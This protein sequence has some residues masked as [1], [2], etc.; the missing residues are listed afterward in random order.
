MA[1]KTG[2]YDGPE[3][4]GRFHSELTVW[5]DEHDTSFPRRA[6]GMSLSDEVARSRANQSRLWQAGW[7][8]YGWPE[9][10]GGLGGSRLLR[11]AVA[12]QAARRGLFYDTL[13]AV[14]EVL[15]PTVVE[16]APGLAERCI[17]PFLDGTEG[18]CQGFSEPEAGSD[19][20]SLRCRAVDAGDHWVVTG[21]KVWTSY[22]QFASRMVLLARTG[23]AEDRHRGITA[24]LV[25]M[26]S[27]GVTVRPLQA[28]NDMAEFSE[29]FF[30]G[31]RVSKDRV[32]GEVGGGWSVAM[33]MLR[34]E[35][36]GI[37]WMLSAWLL[38]ELE[39]LAGTADL[40]V[41]DDEAVG[42]L[43]ASVAALRARSWTTQHRL[44]A[45]AIE[46]PETSIDK[47]LMATAEQELFDLV[48]T[49]LDGVLEF[50]DDESVAWLRSSYMYSRAASVY[51][52]TAEIQRNIV[53]DQV[54]GLRSP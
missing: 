8:R 41:A 20:A 2:P 33:R 25:D 50:A 14:G 13:A 7:L 24:L 5:L 32:I 37:F 47:I 49:S 44:A 34:H 35:R 1:G 48:R 51:G 38:D 46:T 53:A 16:A 21:Q 22:A 39:K 27:P 40:G 10:V 19:L 17:T 4:L 3:G 18:W 42:R 12:E 9:T 11:A 31:V 45:G 52:G 28:I 15:G 6:C 36:G 26:D 30:D 29:T 54:L 43:F 23:S